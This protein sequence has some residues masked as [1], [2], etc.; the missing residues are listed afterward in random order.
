MVAVPRLSAQERRVNPHNMRTWP[1][2]LRWMWVYLCVAHG[3][4]WGVV[5]AWVGV[6]RV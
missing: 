2:W 4:F 6:I 5:L 1:R 3:A